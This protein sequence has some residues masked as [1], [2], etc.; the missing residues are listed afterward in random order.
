MPTLTH[1]ADD[2]SITFPSWV[3]GPTTCKTRTF[4]VTLERTP[5]SPH[6]AIK[7]VKAF[8]NAPLVKLHRIGRPGFYMGWL[9][10]TTVE[11][12]VYR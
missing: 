5:Y 12:R 11:T 10:K 2:A 8:P 3:K 4:S 6:G 9:D 7:V 1:L